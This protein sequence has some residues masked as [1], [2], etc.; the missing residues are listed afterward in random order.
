MS[1][2]HWGGMCPT[3]HRCP[4]GESGALKDVCHW[5]FLCL[6]TA[7]VRVETFYSDASFK[8]QLD[9]VTNSYCYCHF[10]FFH[11]NFSFPKICVLWIS[12]K[13][14]RAK[15]NL[16]DNSINVCLGLKSWGVDHIVSS[17]TFNIR[18]LYSYIVWCNAVWCTHFLLQ[19]KLV[20]FWLLLV[21]YSVKDL[22]HLISELNIGQIGLN[23][24]KKSSLCSEFGKW[25]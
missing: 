17:W 14:R 21:H 8:T 6:T 15:W 19:W 11:L 22:V 23:F 16:T 1:Y 3:D 4:V 24:L 20:G 10:N 2:F 9:S 25:I 12:S 13:K 7:L 5:Y 18:R